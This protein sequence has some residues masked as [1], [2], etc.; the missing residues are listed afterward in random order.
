MNLRY[1]ALASLLAGAAGLVIGCGSKKPPAGDKSAPN[2]T[3]APGSQAT[4]DVGSPLYAPVAAPVYPTVVTRAEP[5][6][7]PNALVQFE[8]RQVISAEVDAAIELFATPISPEEATKLRAQGVEIIYHPRDVLKVVPMKRIGESDEVRDGQAL[9]FLDDRQIAARLDGATKI[10]SAAEVSKLSAADGKVAAKARWDLTIKTSMSGVGSRKDELDDQLT[11]QR[12]VENEAQALQTIAKADQDYAEAKVLLGK[13]KVTS[14]VN[15]VVRSIAKRPGEFVKTGEKIMEIEATDRVRIEGN[16]DVQYAPYV[17]RGMEVTVEPAVPSAPIASH[18][19]HRQAVTGI[20]VTAHPDGPLVVSVGADG[21]ALVWD[22]N[23]G[24]KPNKPT[25][26]H[27]LPHPV[28]VRSVA[29]TPQAAKALLVVTGGDDGKIR[30]WDVANRDKLPNAPKAEPE[31]SHTAAVQAIAIS[32]DGRFFASAAGRDVFVWDLASAKKL[33]ALPAEH[34]DN[35]TS[36]SFTPQDTLVTASKDGSLKVWKLGTEKAGVVR[37]IDHRAGAV[38]VLG[39]SRDGARVL[40]DQDKGRMDLVD[41]ATGQTVGHLQNVS[42]AGSFA[43]LALFGQQDVPFGAKDEALPPY[44]IVTVGGDGDLKGT[45][46]YW[47]A[48]RTGGRGAEVGRLITPGRAPI[49]AAAFSPVRGEPFLVVGT[50]TGGVHLWK[51]SDEARKTHTGKITFIDATDTRYVT[52]RVEMDNRD[53]KLLDH[54][55][56]TIIV[57]V[58]P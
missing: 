6:V 32:P 14:R 5:I 34:R 2:V 30:I 37:T 51:P 11:Y 21:G 22:P 3:V 47:H 10:K 7:I 4:V 12:F 35:V 42:S 57:P 48:P 1:F 31:E 52:V 23:L 29:A 27:N 43:A 39:V 18:T 56:A 26:P 58:N 36:V 33:Y 44:G 19:G 16:L 8:E 41:P 45:V 9:A 13:H 25:V 20:A 17:R 49:T 38:E 53:L 24:K 54:S 50:G 28:G 55:A 15:G 40:F 46:Q